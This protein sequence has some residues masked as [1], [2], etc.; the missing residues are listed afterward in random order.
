MSCRYVKVKPSEISVPE[1]SRFMTHKKKNPC[2]SLTTVLPITFFKTDTSENSNLNHFMLHSD[3]A[4]SFSCHQPFRWL[5]HCCTATAKQWSTFPEEQGNL[6]PDLHMHLETIKMILLL[7]CSRFSRQKPLK[8]FNS[9]HL[10]TYLST[11]QTGLNSQ[12]FG[13]VCTDKWVLSTPL[14]YSQG[15][16]ISTFRAQF[17]IS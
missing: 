14:P 4:M 17:I 9:V 2:N 3:I 11:P 15:R 5:C 8:L 13:R 10:T 12:H 7:T 6:V 16:E 1:T